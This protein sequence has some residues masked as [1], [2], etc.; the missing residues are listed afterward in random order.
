M[1]VRVY[2]YDERSELIGSALAKLQ[3]LLRGH[4]LVGSGV[5]TRRANNDP[6]SIVA[7]EAVA[8]LAPLADQCTAIINELTA[9][10]WD[11]QWMLEGPRPDNTDGWSVVVNDGG[12]G[13]VTRVADTSITPSLDDWSN[14]VDVD[15]FF[16][17]EGMDSAPQDGM[18]KV[19]SVT[20]GQVVCTGPIQGADD[21]DVQ[22]AK[23]TLYAR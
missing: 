19:G 18:Y 20:A 1:A 13:K 10:N 12:F 6:E 23:M 15:D 3:V 9:I 17:L 4:N 21:T 8:A 7:A 2:S 16:L 11:H 14:V 5:S 22:N